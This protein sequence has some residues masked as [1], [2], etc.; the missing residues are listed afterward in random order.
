MALSYGK[1][2]LIVTFGLVAENQFEDY[3]NRLAF[4][5]LS[6]GLDE[7]CESMVETNYRL[8]RHCC[9]IAAR[10]DGVMESQLVK[11]RFADTYFIL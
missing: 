1:T 8:Q 4:R 2:C 5:M 10:E 3:Y 7:L 11:V 6:L 9:L